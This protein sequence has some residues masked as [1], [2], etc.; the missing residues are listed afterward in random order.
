[1]RACTGSGK[2][3]Y[4]VLQDKEEETNNKN[5]SDSDDNDSEDNIVKAVILVPKQE[6]CHKVYSTL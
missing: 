1:M 6:L 4:K 5:G 3:L 2:I